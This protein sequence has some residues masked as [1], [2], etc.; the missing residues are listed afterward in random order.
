[1]ILLEVPIADFLDIMQTS[2]H[3][4]QFVRANAAAFY[5]S[6]IL[7]EFSH[8]ADQIPSGI[9]QWLARP[10]KLRNSCPRKISSR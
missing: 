8:E 6:E 4:R 10:Y 7:Y 5:N 1:M 9:D 3:L 2:K